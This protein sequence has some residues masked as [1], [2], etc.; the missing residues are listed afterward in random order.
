MVE[1][2]CVLTYDDM[3]RCERARLPWW[4]AVAGGVEVCVYTPD[5]YAYAARAATLGA[6][7]AAAQ[8]RAAHHVVHTVQADERAAEQAAGI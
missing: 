3:V 6:A 5:G 8:R 1:L 7:Y 2:A 4:R